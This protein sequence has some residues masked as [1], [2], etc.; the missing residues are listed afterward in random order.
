MDRKGDF[1]VTIEGKKFYVL[2]PRPEDIDIYDI[3]IA[4]SKKC[5]WGGHCLG[6][7]SVAEHA[8]LCSYL[9]PPEMAMSAL[10]HDASEA[11]L[12]DL[13][14][15]IKDMPEFA[16][17][18]EAEDLIHKAVASKFNLDYLDSP[19]VKAADMRSRQIERNQII[20]FPK[21]SQQAVNVEDL[22]GLVLRCL[23]HEAAEVLFLSR[24]RE[25]K[26]LHQS[27]ELDYYGRFFVSFQ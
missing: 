18:R 14:S 24:Y 20:P 22:D 2:D 1:L 27:V 8:V 6:F 4:L 26:S 10:L 16:V 23:T 5:R 3:T 12:P 17:F 19:E 9:V 11:Y 21:T 15:P 7:F 13:P 25:I